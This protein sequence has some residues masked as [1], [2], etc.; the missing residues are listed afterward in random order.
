MLGK[1]KTVKPV[2][3]SQVVPDKTMDVTSSVDKKYR[4]LFRVRGLTNEE[5]HTRQCR[6]LLW[7]MVVLRLLD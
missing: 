4:Q 7:V 1:M 5:K 2:H 3:I 6:K